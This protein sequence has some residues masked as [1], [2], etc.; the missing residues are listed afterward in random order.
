MSV[1]WERD[2]AMWARYE[3]RESERGECYGHH[4]SKTAWGGV[5]VQCGSTVSKG[6]L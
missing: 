1:S 4:W 3:A 5:C 2:E 6:E